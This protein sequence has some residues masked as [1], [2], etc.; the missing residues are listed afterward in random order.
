MAGLGVQKNLD[1]I[2]IAVARD[3]G[4]ANFDSSMSVAQAVST[5]NT[6]MIE[7]HRARLFVLR[8]IFSPGLLRSS[9]G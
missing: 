2:D 5:K 7:A 4:D 8:A 6:P 1:D 3:D 9:S